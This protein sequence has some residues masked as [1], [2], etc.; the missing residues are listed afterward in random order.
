M[1]EKVKR[2]KKKPPPTESRKRILDAAVRLF[3]RHGYAGT[4]LRELATEADVNLAMIN[5]FFGSKKGLLKEILDDFFAGYLRVAR[6]QLEGEGDAADKLD[7]FIRE[8]VRYFAQRRDCLVVVITELPHDDPE[9]IDHKAAWGRQMMAILGKEVCRPLS[10][11]RERP[12][13]PLLIGPMLTSMMASRFLF[14]P[15]SERVGSADMAS[16]VEDY[17]DELSRLILDG[18]QPRR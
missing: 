13:T 9:V 3:A 14:A 11:G 2:G 16:S 15:V 4:G 7:A 12:L 17:A 1:N 8:A 10:L 18:L 5:Y 6:E